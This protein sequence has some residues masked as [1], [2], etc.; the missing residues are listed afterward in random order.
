MKKY[1][2]LLLC[3][4]SIYSCGSSESSLNPT[5]TSSF[6]GSVLSAL[7]SVISQI[8]DPGVYKREGTQPGYEYAEEFMARMSQLGFKPYEPPPTD[9]LT[10]EEKEYLASNPY[11]DVRITSI[12]SSGWPLIWQEREAIIDM[13]AVMRY[14]MNEPD[15]ADKLFSMTGDGGTRLTTGPSGNFKTP[16]SLVNY[17]R[18]QIFPGYKEL[19]K[20]RFIR[21]LLNASFNIKIAKREKLMDGF[22]ESYARAQ[23]PIGPGLYAYP[24][25]YEDYWLK[26]TGRYGG[27]TIEVSQDAMSDLD[28]YYEGSRALCPRP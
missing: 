8:K 6:G 28:P 11:G 23:V 13:F 4:F 26:T 21:L 1:I 3:L 10:Q 27:D 24:D 22:Y 16:E 12:S 18:Y 19:N 5:D 14:I 15:F 20:E 25:E 9:M 7:K 2:Y 17:D